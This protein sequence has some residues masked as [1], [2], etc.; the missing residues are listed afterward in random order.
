MKIR[1]KKYIFD[2]GA[3]DG[4]DGLALALNN[5]DIFVHAF[6]AN[7]ELIKIIKN[8]KKKL[9]KRKGAPIKNYQIHNYAISDRN[10]TALFNIST[11]SRVSSLNNLSKDI[12]KSWPGY[13][14]NIFKVVKKIK[15]KVITL[16]DFME[17]YKIKYIN[18]LHID[19]QG[20][21]LNV[22]KGLKKKINNVIEGE[23]EASLNKKKSAYQNN[24]TVKDVKNFFQ[25]TAIKINKIINV[26]HLSK[27]G[28]LNNEADIYFFNKKIK[29]KSKI[30]KKYNK[31]YYGRVLN[32]NTY[33][34]DDIKD[35][36]IR[37]YNKIY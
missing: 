4:A 27:R 26:N 20:H 2:V 21:D 9:E 37:I 22:L 7:P 32:E 28:V 19:T 24:H 34:K 12:E 11:N 10:R 16:Y 31:R 3:N 18:F 6:E 25:K 13:H 30:N 17:K 33:L 29:I 35:F 8:L 36:L 1:H 14:E 23:M 5:K 15:V